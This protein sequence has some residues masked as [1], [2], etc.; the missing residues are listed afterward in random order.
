LTAPTLIVT[1]A[2]PP[3]TQMT[4]VEEAVIVKSTTWKVTVAAWVVDPLVPV[5]VTVLVPVVAYVQVKVEVP[6]VV[7]VVRVTLGALRLQAVPPF[8]DRLTVPVNPLMAPTVIVEVPA[9]P[10]FT[11]TVVELAV[12]EK[13]V[14]AVNVTV[15]V[16]VRLP[17]VP[18]TATVKGPAV[19]NVHVRVEVREVAVPVNVTL[20]T[21]REQL[22]PPFWVRPT[23]PVKPLTVVTVTVEL[24]GEPTV[25][26]TLDGLAAIVKSTTWNATVAVW[27]RLPLE[28]VTVT[29]LFPAV[30]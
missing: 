11:T 4:V 23:V 30:A 7:V 21:L 24:A 3:T 29:L 12:T 8:W 17:L 6:D 26:V 2:V 25:S 28:P 27:V 20:A 13:S 14:V 15:V 9:E 5:T 22:V 19:V 16:W 18:V 10:A 1:L